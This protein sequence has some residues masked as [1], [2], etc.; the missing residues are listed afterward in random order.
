MGY[1]SDVRI[2]VSKKGYEKLEEFVKKYLKDKELDEAEYNLLERAEIKH[3]C[4][5][6]YYI[7]WNWIK[8]DE[9]YY[10]DAK[11]IMEGL[12]YLV[13]NNLAYRYVRIGEDLTDMEEN[14]YDSE[15][16]EDV[17]DFPFIL[18]RFDDEAF[19]EENK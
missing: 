5:N 10:E 14:F 16:D 7:G 6:L 9:G 19:L 1:R 17:L 3:E 13:E 11:A 8:W 12:S 2:V 15:Q 18:R 4:K